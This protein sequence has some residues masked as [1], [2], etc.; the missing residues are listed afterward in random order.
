VAFALPGRALMVATDILQAGYALEAAETALAF[1]DCLLFP[2]RRQLLIES[3]PVKLGSRAFDTL[4]ILVE[5]EGKLVTKNELLRR[6]WHNTTVVE[7]NISAQIAA[8]RKVLGEDPELVQTDAG[9]GYRFTGNVRKI[10]GASEVPPLATSPPVTREPLSAPATNL[11][12]PLSLLI[13][14]E[15]E[16]AELQD[17]IA[18]RRL[19]TLTGAGGI[20]KT[21]LGLEAARLALPRFADGAHVIELGPLADAELLPG[22][23]ARAL[24]IEPGT[25]RTTVEQLVAVLGRKHLLLV[26]DNCEHLVEGVALTAEALLRGAPRLH[27]MTTSQEVLSAEGECI[28]RVSPL[29][30]PVADTGAAA[31]ATTYSAVR[32][33]VERARS[34]DAAFSLDDRSALAVSRIC[35]RLDGIPLA[36]ELAAACVATIGVDL[37]ASRLDD[38]F[39]LLTGGRR[40]A[41]RRHQT[42]SGMLDWSYGLLE[43]AERAMLHRVTVFSG[44]FTLDGA[45]AVAAGDDA[46]RAQAADHV[47]RLVR[48]SL[49]TL[50]IRSP[51]P[52]YRLLDTTRAYAFAKLV[53]SGEFAAVARRHADY[54]RR[55]MEHARTGWQSTPGSELVARYAPEIDNIRAALDWAL[56]P[57]GDAEI[58]I[59]LAAASVQL[60]KLLAIL[61]E[62]RD[63]V[64]LALSRLDANAG[65]QMRHEMLLQAALGISLLWAEGAVNAVLAAA[66]RT[67]E[68][69]ERLDDTEYQLRALYVRWV[70]LRRLGDYRNSLA[71]ADQFCRIAEG[72]ADVVV[73]LT[74]ARMRGV[75]LHH[76]GDQTGAR[77]ALERVLEADLMEF[78][79]SFVASFGINQRVAARS[80]LARILWLLGFPERAARQAE[81]GVEEA[82]A[83]GH[84]TSH[85]LALCE[86]ACFIAAMTEDLPATERLATQLMESAEAHGMGMWQG[87][88]L[89]FKGW[90]AVRRGDGSTGLRILRQAF[91]SFPETR[92]NLRH[93]IFLE[94][95]AEA[96]IGSGCA[97]Q[98]LEIFDDAIRES[99][100]MGG[101]WR[102]PELLRLRGEFALKRGGNTM[103]AAAKDFL[104]AA[105]LAR[106]QGARAW[107]L[108]AA[109][110][111]ARLR[112][113]QGEPDKAHAVLL[114]IY[115]RF[116]EGLETADLRA[117][118]AVV[119]SLRHRHEDPAADRDVLAERGQQF[120]RGRLPAV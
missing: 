83:V 47:T 77:F 98:G 5:A 65:P 79:Q 29:K 35:R 43:R 96:V 107:E 90:V 10:A 7:K 12:I 69:A 112:G 60:W 3:R 13:G 63:L 74:G 39:Q 1:G 48:K 78:H 111:L 32:L 45:V 67:L 22:A 44:S 70:H 21:R 8:I 91:N 64:R 110:S 95:L 40:T 101:Y 104:E 92:V 94:A 20:G 30:V 14:R 41:L 113:A 56:A 19:V 62:Y 52:R 85:C 106:R 84:A 105:D 31:E 53:E 114:P 59:A 50:D 102:M 49:V 58:G 118:R 26:L 97:D 54:Y 2:K 61:A 24:E 11:M 75:S 117:A 82:L 72:S 33:F 36:I 4:V 103:G 87:Y 16:L 28:Y 86:G 34:A 73:I 119:E 27:I 55:L 57:G 6:V 116:S 46:E 120:G 76:L 109:T 51:V 99:A 18:S 100:R 15:R 17:L 89:A 115:E 68:L 66:Q 108:R 81:L 37:L 88:A 25:N 80:Y 9:R 38:R 42:L 23:I 93:P 71:V